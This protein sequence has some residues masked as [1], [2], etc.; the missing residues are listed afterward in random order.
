MYRCLV[1]SG[2]LSLPGM[3]MDI[4]CMAQPPTQAP[5]AVHFSAAKTNDWNIKQ[6]TSTIENE[7][8][9]VYSVY[10]VRN[11]IAMIF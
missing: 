5:Q 10:S 11:T 4:L 8:Y 1:F 3:M 9:Q 7:F 2:L 6:R